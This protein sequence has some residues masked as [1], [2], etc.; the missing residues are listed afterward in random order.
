MNEL[1]LYGTARSL[2]VVC[3]RA[4]AIPAPP[5]PHAIGSSPSA[6]RALLIGLDDA[7]GTLRCGSRVVARDVRSFGV[8]W[9]APGGGGAGGDGDDDDAEA[10]CSYAAAAY[11]AGA[12]LERMEAD[13]GE[14]GFDAEDDSRRAVPRVVYVTRG[15]DLRVAELREMA[16]ASDA[17]VRRS[18]THVS[19]KTD[20]I[21][22]H[23]GTHA[24]AAGGKRGASVGVGGGVCMDQLHVSM[25]AAMRPADAGRGAD[26]RVRRVEEVRLLP[27]RPRSRGARRSLRTFPVVTPSDCSPCDPIRRA[28]CAVPRGR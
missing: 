12:W 18:D 6:P 23:H 15:D 1:F 26:S 8:H 21:V 22:G 14:G 20:T 11:A 5:A 13:V 3:A 28:V 4:R 7:T 25:R 16:G 9:T 24:T 10:S 27:V 19:D 17:A 2:P